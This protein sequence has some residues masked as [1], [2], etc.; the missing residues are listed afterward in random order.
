METV[1]L[2]K[3]AF[4][5]R[6]ENSLTSPSI[7]VKT[8]RKNVVIGEKDS[9]Y[10]VA[11]R[12]SVFSVRATSSS[13]TALKATTRRQNDIMDTHNRLGHPHDE[14][15]RGISRTCEIS[16]IGDW[17]PFAGYL[18]R[19]KAHTITVLKKTDRQST[20]KLDS[21]FMGMDG[22][23][24]VPSKDESFY[25]MIT[26]DNYTRMTWIRFIKVKRS[27]E[28]AGIISNFIANISRPN[29]L[30]IKTIRTNEG[31]E[32]EGVFHQF[33]YATVHP[34]RDD[35]SGHAQ[36]QRV[37]REDAEGTGREGNCNNL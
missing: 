6:L 23:K 9:A 37:G 17:T 32:H 35:G 20:T 12:N 33:W 11:R 5:P 1:V 36:V 18:L 2:Q 22:A 8:P 31:G 16:H 25:V 21:V 34:A 19:S 29:R 24:A 30:I 13:S 3:M 7:S 28:I 4:Y 10:N 26:A 15:T 27:K 14:L